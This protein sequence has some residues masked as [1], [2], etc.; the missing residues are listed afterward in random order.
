MAKVFWIVL[1]ASLLIAVVESYKNKMKKLEERSDAELMQKAV[2]RLI[3]SH[4]FSKTRLSGEREPNHH[5]MID[6]LKRLTYSERTLNREHKRRHRFN[7]K[8]LLR[9]L[10]AMTSNADQA[11]R[12]F[13]EIRKAFNEKHK[14]LK[15]N[16]KNFKRNHKKSFHKMHDNKKRHFRKRPGHT[17]AKLAVVHADNELRLHR[18]KAPKLIIQ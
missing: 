18:G 17:K 1:L 8:K 2:K 9:H 3:S 12:F 6:F 11:K 16:H 13:K 5:Q 7:D 10:K 14:N 4:F 15:R